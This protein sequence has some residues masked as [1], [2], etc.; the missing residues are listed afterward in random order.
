MPIDPGAVGAEGTPSERSWNF[1]DAVLY[2]LGVGC[3]VDD[4]RFSTEKNQLVLPT[5]AV[6][7]GM[8]GIPFDRIGKFNFAMLV[9]GEQAIEVSGPI[10]PNGKVR[11]KGRVA[12]IYDKGKGAL[13]VFECESVDAETG[14]PRFKNRMSAFI[15]GEGGFG[16]DRGPQT[17]PFELPNRK[18]DHELSYETSRDQALLYR[19]S[20]DMN[21]L[22]SDPDVAKMVGFPKPILHGLCTYGFTGRA[23]LAALCGNDPARFRS[24]DGRFSK[25]VFPGESLTVKMW[26]DGSQALFQTVNPAGD[27]V[28]DQGRFGFTS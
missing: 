14:A 26:V 16:G 28:L 1:R 25:P 5:F 23:L 13:V 20:G 22:H 8:G 9:H 24:M 6:I 27:V 21:P 2:A 12:G 19:L 10:P 7:V 3:G 17:P 15:R 4:L 18:P 11:T